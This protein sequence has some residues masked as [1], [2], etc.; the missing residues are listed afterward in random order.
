MQPILVKLKI[1]LTSVRIRITAANSIRMNW[2]PEGVEEV[3]AAWWSLKERYTG[4]KMMLTRH[5]TGW[6]RIAAF[7]EVELNVSRGL[8]ITNRLA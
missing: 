8:V 7:M 2:K 6:I 5:W 4:R 1:M 3:A